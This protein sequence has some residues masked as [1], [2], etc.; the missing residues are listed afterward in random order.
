[1][2]KLMFA[3]IGLLALT[4]CVGTRN[5]ASETIEFQLDNVSHPRQILV[6][7]ESDIALQGQSVSAV[8]Q[9]N[10]L[11]SGPQLA[12]HWRFVNERKLACEIQQTLPPNA[13][14]RVEIGKEFE[15]PG[16]SLGSAHSWQFSTPVATVNWYK[17]YSAAGFLDGGRIQVRHPFAVD[18]SQFDGHLWA[19]HASGKRIALT[20]DGSAPANGRS[21]LTVQA[22]EQAP[23]GEYQL[24]LDS[25]FRFAP[26]ANQLGEELL[27]GKITHFP[28]FQFLGAF[29]YRDDDYQ[30]LSVKQWRQSGCS[31]ANIAL[32]FSHPIDGAFAGE[33]QGWLTD[34]HGQGAVLAQIESKPDRLY[35]HF[36]LQPESEYSLYLN[37]LKSMGGKVLG[38]AT[39]GRIVS[40]KP[41][42]YWQPQIWQLITEADNAS[43]INVASFGFEQ[44]KGSVEVIND[45]ESLVAK[46]ASADSEGRQAESVIWTR[47]D[48]GRLNPQSWLAD[49]Q[50]MVFIRAQVDD[51]RQRQLSAIY[52]GFNLAVLPGA[53]WLV[54]AQDWFGEPVADAQVALVCREG[55]SNLGK[56]DA[57][58]LL[59]A[60]KQP[61]ASR[62]SR[63]V[64]WAETPQQQAMMPLDAYWY[65]GGDKQPSTSWV[66]DGWTAQPVYRPGETLHLGVLARHFSR[67][68]VMDPSSQSATLRLLNDDQKEIHVWRDV[69]LSDLGLLSVSARLPESLPSGHYAVNL[70]WSG[71]QQT[72]AG[73]LVEE[74]IAPAFTVNFVDTDTS[75]TELNFSVRQINGQPLVDA[76]IQV[77]TELTSSALP[78][79]LPEDYDFSFES[80]QPVIV[81]PSLVS[82]GGGNYRVRLQTQ[83]VPGPFQRANVTL[84]VTNKD[85]ETQHVNRPVALPGPPLLAG[86][87]RT[88]QGLGFTWVN[89]AF[90]ETVAPAGAKVV[91]SYQRFG[92]QVTVAECQLAGMRPECGF[93]FPGHSALQLSLEWDQLDAPM[94]MERWFHSGEQRP[95]EQ[96]TFALTSDLEPQDD[97]LHSQVGDQLALTLSSDIAGKG[98][99]ALSYDGKLDVVPLSINQGDTPIRVDLT[100]EHQPLV[101]V[102][103]YQLLSREDIDQD[104]IRARSRQAH[105]S[106]RVMPQQAAPKVDIQ[107]SHPDMKPGTQQTVTLTSDTSAHVQ[108]WLVNRALAP[109]DWD[110]SSVESSLYW[111]LEE[112]L[113]HTRHSN[114][115]DIAAKLNRSTQLQRRYRTSAPSQA[116]AMFDEAAVEKIEVSGSRIS[117]QGEGQSE[118]SREFADSEFAH[119]HWLGQYAV[120]ANQP[121]SVA[122]R[123]PMLLSGWEIK[124]VAVTPTRVSEQSHIFDV[125][126]DIEFQLNLPRRMFSTDQAEVNLQVMNFSDQTQA[127]TFVLKGNYGVI[128]EVDMQLK[129]GR[130]SHLIPLPLLQPGQHR[131]DIWSTAN[132]DYVSR[133]K[134]TVVE[135]YNQQNRRWLFDATQQQA[136]RVSQAMVPATL[137]MSR[138][139]SNALSPDWQAEIRYNRDYLHHCWEQIL[140]RAVAYSV[141][142]LAETDWPE[143]Q[144]LLASLLGQQE[145]FFGN[146]GYGYFDATNQS[147]WLTAYTLLAQQ[148]LASTALKFEPLGQGLRAQV[149]RIMADE[150]NSDR[151]RLFAFWA[152]SEAE[153]DKVSLPR[154]LNNPDSYGNRLLGLLGKQAQGDN[155]LPLLQ[156]ML[157]EGYQDTSTSHF[158]T[159]QQQ[160]MALMILPASHKQHSHLLRRVIEQQGVSGHFGNTTTNAICAR[161]LRQY[162][163]QP[164]VTEVKPDAIIAA[165]GQQQINVSLDNH[166]LVWLDARYQVALAKLPEESN[167]L[168]V[169]RRVFR[170]QGDQWQ[171]INDG[172]RLNVGDE[173]KVVLQLTSAV[174]RQQ[175]AVTDWLPAAWHVTQRARIG[176]PEP[177]PLVERQRIAPYNPMRV[178]E[179]KVSFYPSYVQAGE[180]QFEYYVQVRFAGEFLAPGTYAEA[181]Y[182]PEVNARGKAS[183]WRVTP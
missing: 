162:H 152:L 107:V 121:L 144:Q 134:I 9:Q 30:S 24:L 154:N 175:V 126:Q 60:D 155:V 95:S 2:K 37:G 48:A 99:L 23:G 143:G 16:G 129:P 163:Q 72:I 55:I 106:V 39:D 59:I 114:W 88:E 13:D 68:W 168:R 62:L 7:F 81:N 117:P 124:T 89:D 65:Y 131:L 141:N 8:Q 146:Q 84:A 94:M 20:L 63:C 167:G 78:D 176:I 3:L 70:D 138:F 98:W 93:D 173:L 116:F 45:K 51:N 91:V 14:F 53:K 73:V 120:Q 12:C 139:S 148:W 19:Q 47:H 150:D 80:Q 90:T 140:S 109:W 180:Q 113:A 27:L 38:N 44:I 174:A 64:M 36:E 135:P 79:T 71:Q 42:P 40:G 170:R 83:G 108:L 100:D 119:S 102:H 32:S 4:S 137:T 104:S 67:S 58:G 92:L 5:A 179:N 54:V 165:D 118:P 164:V 181:M 125:K 66:A 156:V 1:M 52:A 69:Q 128:A 158:T 56:T 97:L 142:P 149:R 50:G 182:Q 130:T 85:G 153:N 159:T 77:D 177:L 132:P 151:T 6:T 87:V 29:C 17:S 11:V 86:V 57:E 101:S 28:D 35:Y 172:Q 46:L 115:V 74:Y 105:L 171:V 25:G 34:S 145:A 136:V 111:Q 21:R 75:H 123:A 96:V 133:A 49:R 161:A 112:L 178:F 31:P 183:R 166:Q 157:D 61:T 22:I 160:C 10:L 76:R 147:D 33:S 41:D 110:Q 15:T 103:V 169:T 43:A 18:A 127:H 26:G 82:E 122:F